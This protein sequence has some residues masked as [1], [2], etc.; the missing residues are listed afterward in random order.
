MPKPV[1]PYDVVL[2]G[3]LSCEQGVALRDTL[4][5]ARL[6][7]VEDDAP[8]EE[9][10]RA[11]ADAR[12]ML[13]LHYTKQ[14][15]PAPRLEFF[16]VAGAGWDG[17]D[18]GHLPPGVVVAN[19]YGH[20]EAIAEYVVLSMLL[21]CSTFL[22][23]DRTFRDGSWRMSGRTDGPVGREL[24]ECTVGILGL[25]RI[26]RMVSRRARCLGAR[27]I[28]CTRTP[29]GKEEHADS[30]VG[31]DQLDPFLEACDFLVIATALGSETERRI[32]AAELA[33]MKRSAVLINVARGT[34]VDE[35]A[36]FHA[37]KD[38]VIGG[39]VLD[40]WYRYPTREEPHPPPS[41][42]P[43]AELPNVLMTPHSSAWTS[44]MLRRRWGF[45][46]ENIARFVRGIEPEN[47]VHRT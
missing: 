24:G 28:A 16:Q 12:I 6:I 5:E 30:I 21:K 7:G 29:T 3:T 35:Q 8:Y 17:I 36:L 20:E 42:Y 43:F 10:E 37:L 31:L 45:I 46:A 13:S 19:A 39:A 4:P 22:E 1:D 25:G 33:R 44:G 47:V 41:A 32:G 15:P 18:V 2:F 9:A 14:M 38:G 34:V 26:G 27:V 40:V 23:A 11:L